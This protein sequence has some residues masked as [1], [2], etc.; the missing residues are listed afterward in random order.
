MVLRAKLFLTCLLIGAL[1]APQSL[2]AAQSPH[3]GAL[4]SLSGQT[5]ANLTLTVGRES[6]GTPFLLSAAGTRGRYLVLTGSRIK[7][8]LSREEPLGTIDLR[9]TSPDK[10]EVGL[11][12]PRGARFDVRAEVL[13]RSLATGNP[14]QIRTTYRFNHLQVTL[15]SRRDYVASRL[16]S[17]KERE[18]ADLFAGVASDGSITGL[19]SQI[20]P[21]L[22]GSSLKMLAPLSLHEAGPVPDC[23]DHA[24]DCLA[25]VVQ[26][27]GGIGALIGFC[28]LTFGIGCIGAILAHPVLG[29]LLAFDCSKAAHSCGLTH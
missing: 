8:E 15:D 21:F 1:V 27:I 29:V 20:E 7:V 4:Q 25:A 23:A 10:L 9:R 22:A 2:V 24:K 12:S 16:R 28:G 13:S 26:Y 5:L 17:K 11:S 19:A 6:N 14:E 3:S 18:L